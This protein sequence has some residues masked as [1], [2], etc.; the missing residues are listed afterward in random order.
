M[1]NNKQLWKVRVPSDCTQTLSRVRAI[2]STV[3]GGNLFGSLFLKARYLENSTTVCWTL[4]SIALTLFSTSIG[5]VDVVSMLFSLY[6]SRGNYHGPPP[7]PSVSGSKD[8]LLMSLSFAGTCVLQAHSSTAKKMPQLHR[9]CSGWRAGSRVWRQQRRKGWGTWGESWLAL[10]LPSW[11][12]K[13][14]SL[15]LNTFLGSWVAPGCQGKG[16]GS[17]ERTIT[18]LFCYASKSSF[19]S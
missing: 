16:S 1:A 12:R 5:P 18:I 19:M 10:D 6:M 11:G 17:R 9:D 15:L 4:Q 8:Q 14:T 2:P 13:R 7:T 3:S